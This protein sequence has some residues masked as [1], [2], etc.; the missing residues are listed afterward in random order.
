M[1]WHRRVPIH[2]VGL[3]QAVAFCRFTGTFSERLVIPCFFR[4]SG[5]FTGSWRLSLLLWAQ[6]MKFEAALILHWLLPLFLNF[7]NMFVISF[8]YLIWPDKPR[9]QHGIFIFAPFLFSNHTRSS[10]KSYKGCSWSFCWTTICC[11]LEVSCT[12]W[13]RSGNSVTYLCWG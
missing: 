12:S 6:S 4:L 10:T 9:L 5:G 8:R 2:M 1:G 11:I 3:K 7:I 13:G